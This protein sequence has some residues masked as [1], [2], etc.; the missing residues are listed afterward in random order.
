[1]IPSNRVA[2]HP[3]KILR[4]EFLE[5]LEI[6]QKALADH[7]GIPVQRINEIV[8]GKRGVTPNTAWLLS[9]A[10]KTSPEFWLNLQAVHDLSA[11]RPKSEVLPLVSMSA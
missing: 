5:P 11:Q 6:T 1:M 2:A 7:I 4:E 10:F 8:R 3:G 9:Q